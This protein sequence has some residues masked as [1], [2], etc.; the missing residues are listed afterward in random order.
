MHPEPKVP[1]WER[2]S[3]AVKIEKYDMPNNSVYWF[4]N[5]WQGV[6]AKV[7]DFRK[8]VM[9]ELEE[10]FSLEQESDEEDCPC[11]PWNDCHFC[12]GAMRNIKNKR[13]FDECFECEYPLF[14]GENTPEMRV[15]K[16]EDDEHYFCSDYCYDCYLDNRAIHHNSDDES[17]DSDDESD[18]SDDEPND[19]EHKSTDEPNDESD[20]KSDKSEE[21]DDEFYDDEDD[22]EESDA[23]SWNSELE[24]FIKQKH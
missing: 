5:Q 8:R 24:A 9:H 11:C 12:E 22:S 21:S 3:D 20:D 19:S 18:D 4:Y 6:S 10:K 16:T 15:Y 13:I 17:D 2:Y 7:I 1:C 23:E 14:F